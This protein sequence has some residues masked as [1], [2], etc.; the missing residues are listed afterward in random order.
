[1]G[2]IRLGQTGEGSYVLR[3][4]SPLPAAGV[5]PLHSPRDALLHLH[6]ATTSAL[7]AAELARG[8]GDTAFV[9]RIGDGVSANLSEPLA[10]LG[11]QRQSTFELSF[12]W[13]LASPVAVE[14]PLLRFDSRAISAIKRGGKFLRK[15]PTETTAT[16]TG[17]VVDLHRTP[18]D[19]LGKV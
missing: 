1:I 9:E 5:T 19:K 13:A 10:N 17:R 12:S 16:V 4:E 8:S 2:N 18:T 6:Q 15:Y 14:T 11:G 3:I 7:E